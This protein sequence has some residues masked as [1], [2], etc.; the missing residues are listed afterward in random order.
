MEF[1]VLMYSETFKLIGA[2][3]VLK[4]V[5]SLALD[6]PDICLQFFMGHLSR[7][8]EKLFT[9]NIV[10]FHAVIYLSR[11]PPKL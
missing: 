9:H 1:F 8:E 10:C 6:F 4:F 2:A 5:W 11:W 3:T 7:Q